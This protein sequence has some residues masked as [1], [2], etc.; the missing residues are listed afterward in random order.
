MVSAR[1]A[2]RFRIPA[3][4]FSETALV[5]RRHRLFQ[6]ILAATDAVAEDLLGCGVPARKLVVTGDP[7][8]D[9]VAARESEAVAGSATTWRN[10]MNHLAAWMPV[11]V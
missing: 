2:A 6:R 8:S 9:A 7:R 10:S 3:C 11:E 4:V 1:L 5:A